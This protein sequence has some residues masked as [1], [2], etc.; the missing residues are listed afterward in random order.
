VPV[1]SPSQVLHRRP[2][3]SGPSLYCEQVSSSHIR[4]HIKL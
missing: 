4:N 1:Q 3:E 2:R